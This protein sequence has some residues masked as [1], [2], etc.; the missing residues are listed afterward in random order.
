MKIKY[1]VRI[2]INLKHTLDTINKEIINNDLMYFNRYKIYKG[3]KVDS[4]LT[5]SYY[6]TSTAAT[7]KYEF[8]DTSC[9]VYSA[10]PVFLEESDYNDPDIIKDKVK[11]FLEFNINL[12]YPDSDPTSIYKTEIKD[13]E[14]IDIEPIEI[15]D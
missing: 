13:I 15:E 5:S 11:E 3:Q 8:T 7:D 2:I 12:V 10:I 1:D 4:G 9:I 14:I 6:L